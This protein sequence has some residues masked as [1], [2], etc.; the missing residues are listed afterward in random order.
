MRAYFKQGSPAIQNQRQH[1]IGTPLWHIYQTQKRVKVMIRQF[2][3]LL[4]SA[5]I[6]GAMV[7]VVSMQ[8]ATA[9]ADTKS[10]DTLKVASSIAP[11]SFLVRQIGG[12]AI[13]SHLIL[14][15]NQSAHHTALRPSQTK[16]IA[17]SDVIFAIDPLMEGGLAKFMSESPQ[18]WVLF[19]QAMAD[20]LTRREDD[21]DHDDHDDHDE[22]KDHDEHDDHDDHHDDHKGHDDHDEHDDHHDD[23][24]G[25]EDHDDHDDHDEHKGHDD[26]D[27]HDDHH[28]DHDDHHDEHKGHD[29]H[30][31]HHDHHAHDSFYDYHLFF[32]PVKMSQMAAVI[33][34][35]L[36]KKAP[37][38]KDMF[39][40]NYEGAITM[41][42]AAS[43][44]LSSKLA[45]TAPNHFIA[46]H[47]MSLYLE[48]DFD[49]EAVGF[50][51]GHDHGKPSAKALRALQE[52]ATRKGAKCIFY[53][54]QIG[55]RL[56]SQLAADMDLPMVTL[57]PLGMSVGEDDMI[58]AYWR[59]V[60][61]S[62][63]RCLS[64]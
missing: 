18:K 39:Q 41:L 25:H 2:G 37:E 45:A 42:D 10:A 14:P 27:D 5:Y 26:H 11:I 32:S 54:P 34:D 46:M 4:N 63:E 30:D 33:R 55:D 57:D 19:S 13:E 22:H 20:Q 16:I 7:T 38:H 12:D 51:L 28:D 1:A 48:Q 61:A 21:E 23:H 52:T 56:I 3:K 58:D 36:G 64:M 15:A 62:F 43:A 8:S 50:V 60:T 49:I 59:D 17:Q 35:E 29:E 31:D 40:A 53:E 44:T 9:L 47:D 6:G 24:K